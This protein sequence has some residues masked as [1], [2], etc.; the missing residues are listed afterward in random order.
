MK[1]EACPRTDS[2]RNKRESQSLEND[3]RNVGV[4]IADARL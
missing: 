1:E 4:L 2:H 3:V